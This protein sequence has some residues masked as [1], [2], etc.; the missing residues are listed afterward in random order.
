MTTENVGRLHEGYCRWVVNV[1][2]DEEGGGVTPSLGAYIRGLP[3]LPC[4]P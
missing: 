1:E 3:F 4:L 2:E